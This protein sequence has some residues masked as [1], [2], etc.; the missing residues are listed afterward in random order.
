M[1]RKIILTL[2]SFVV[3]AVT[4]AADC[5]RC[6]GSGRVV[7]VPEVSSYGVSN[8]K[9][10]CPY[11]HR[12]VLPGHRCECP[13]CHGTGNASGS[14]RHS[15]SSSNDADPSRMGLTTEE[16]LEVQQLTSQLM[17][18]YT[19]YEDCTPC[20]G[21]GVCPTCRNG[22]NP[23]CPCNG[24][25]KCYAC[26]GTGHDPTPRYRGVDD[27]TKAR[28]EARIREITARGEQRLR[29]QQGY[30]ADEDDDSPRSDSYDADERS[31]RSSS[32][33]SSGSYSS[34]A[35]TPS[36]HHSKWRSFR[37][38]LIGIAV[39]GALIALLILGLRKL[40]RFFRHRRGDS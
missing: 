12:K 33:S 39:Y 14:V 40:I 25:L 13:V 4:A 35:Y 10:E 1:L 23:I 24:T 9:V 16:Y 3:V 38:C 37:R 21:T 18:K 8:R 30:N 6:H 19:Y 34:T 11:C 20:G 36:S 5:P 22:I 32:T 7:A 28:L 2:F 15:S 17:Q 29:E 31:P 26:N 27:E